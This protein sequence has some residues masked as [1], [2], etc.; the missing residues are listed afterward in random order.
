MEKYRPPSPYIEH[1]FHCS[2]TG[3]DPHPDADRYERMRFWDEIMEGH[4]RSTEAAIRMSQAVE[5]AIR[6]ETKEN[7]DAKEINQETNAIQTK[8]EE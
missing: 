6:Q 4:V 3:A 2:I 8:E 5:T 7:D 1:V